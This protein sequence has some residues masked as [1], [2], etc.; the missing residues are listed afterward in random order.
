MQ[1]PANRYFPYLHNAIPT[2][3]SRLDGSWLN[4]GDIDKAQVI[5]FLLI[6]LLYDVML[7]N[8]LPNPICLLT[9]SLSMNVLTLNKH[10]M[11][12]TTL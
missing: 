9:I 4:Q 11:H 3:G 1:F 5:P 10:V 7:T 12:A 6:N 2:T 8:F